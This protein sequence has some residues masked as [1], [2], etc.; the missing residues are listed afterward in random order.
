L[1]VILLSE[2]RRSRKLI[3]MTKIDQKRPKFYGTNSKNQKK[4]NT[5]GKVQKSLRSTNK[6]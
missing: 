2:M 3:R 1:E 5:T 4:K 6:R